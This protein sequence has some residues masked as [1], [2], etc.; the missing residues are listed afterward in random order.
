MLEMLKRLEEDSQDDERELLD[1]GDDAEDDLVQRLSNVNLGEFWSDMSTVENCLLNYNVFKDTASYEALWDLLNGSEREKFLRIVQD[2][3]SEQAKELLESEELLKHRID[4]WWEAPSLVNEESA[5][6]SKITIAN[7]GPPPPVMEVPESLVNPV[8]IATGPPLLY[9]IAAVWFVCSHSQ[10]ACS[11]NDCSF[12]L[13]YAYVS[14]HLLVSPLHDLARDSSDRQE[15]KKL[16]STI[17]PFLVQKKTRAL[18]GSLDEVVTDVWSRFES[19]SDAGR[20]FISFPWRLPLTT[21]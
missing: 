13:A 5:P 1:G 19:V 14:R 12:S 9:N 15:A 7:F 6:R 20:V 21:R 16:I 17:V 4:P 11:Q 2:T 10:S 8:T 3:S 18:F